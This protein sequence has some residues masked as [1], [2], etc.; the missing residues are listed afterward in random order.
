MIGLISYSAYLWHQPLMSLSR[1]YFISDLDALKIVLVVLITFLLAYFSWRFI[2]QPFR[3]R[4]E[5][6]ERLF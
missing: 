1:Y 3:D 5:F 6:L 2:E 4:E